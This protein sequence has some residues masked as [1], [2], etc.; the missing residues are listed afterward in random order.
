MNAVSTLLELVGF[1]AIA[2]GVYLF[3]WRAAVIFAGVV[4]VLAG[5]IL[6]A[7]ARAVE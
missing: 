4:C 3:D 7:P 5:F 6:G 1:A 2:Y